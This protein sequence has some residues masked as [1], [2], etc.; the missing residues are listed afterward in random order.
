[1]LTIGSLPQI[2]GNEGYSF[3][4]EKIMDTLAVKCGLKSKE[5]LFASEISDFLALIVKEYTKWNNSSPNR[6]AFSMLLKNSNEAI[7][8]FWEMIIQIASSNISKDKQY[9][10]IFDTLSLIYTLIEKRKDSQLLAVS[11]NSLL[12]SV[13]IPS[14]RWK[15]GSPSTNIREAAIKCFLRL[16]EYGLV[17][18]K[19]IHSKFK[20]YFAILKGCLDDD[21]S[22]NL[23]YISLVLM[24]S[25]ITYLKGVWECYALI[26]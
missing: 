22:P 2:D 12:D 7:D 18:K 23:R 5:E 26:R 9:M 13:I 25:I 11:A 20:D 3:F 21:W 14:A 17:E 8:G 1:M 24:Q 4:R 10:L 16:L 19:F 15:A 6:Y